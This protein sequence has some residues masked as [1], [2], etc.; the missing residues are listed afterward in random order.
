M[1]KRRSIRLPQL[2]QPLHLRTGVLHFNKPQKKAHKYHGIHRYCV[3][4]KK[5]GVPERKYMSHSAEY[6]TSVHTN[7]TIKDL[8]GGSVGSITDTVKQYKKS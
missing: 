1:Q 7:R 4:C 8:M 6:C 2:G 5:A 3:L